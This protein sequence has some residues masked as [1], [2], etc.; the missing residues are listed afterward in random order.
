MI[1]FRFCIWVETVGFLTSFIIL[2]VISLR[3]SLNHADV[4]SRK[5]SLGLMDESYNLID[6]WLTNNLDTDNAEELMLKL[7]K[8]QIGEFDMKIR[9]ALNNIL[10]MREITNKRQDWSCTDF[11]NRVFDSNERFN[12][13][14]KQNLQEEPSKILG[15]LI[16]FYNRKHKEQCIVAYND[17]FKEVTKKSSLKNLVLYYMLTQTALEH[18]RS[19]NESQQIDEADDLY[20]TI[21]KNDSFDDKFVRKPE[22]LF[23]VLKQVTKGDLVESRYL[24]LKPSLR[25]EV[26]RIDQVGLSELYEK[27]LV[28]PCGFL[29]DLLGDKIFYQ[30]DESTW[31]PEVK[32]DIRLVR[33]MAAQQTCR[34]LLDNQRKVLK[35]LAIYTE[36]Y[37][38]ASLVS[39]IESD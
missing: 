24:T 28:E 8:R 34:V 36:T 19:Q 2:E 1:K 16:S 39:K 20:K 15:L 14:N 3:I 32:D 29:R 30:Q 25:Q 27:Y 35:N 13:Q 17:Q 33:L 38:F 6:T 22:I 37:A 10:L 12:R 26:K 4:M 9:E 18:L 31:R 7:E 5:A 21:I 11:A 23:S